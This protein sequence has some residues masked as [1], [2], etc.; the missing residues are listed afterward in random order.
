MSSN[1]QLIVEEIASRT[2]TAT[3]RFDEP[4]NLHEPFFM[5][6]EKKYLNE[7]IDEGF[8]SYVGR[9]VGE[10]ERKLSEVFEVPFAVAMSNG[11]VAL[12]M[13][14]VVA[15]VQAGQEVIMP[16]MSFIA[17]ANAVSHL[18][19]IPHFVDSE[20]VQMGIDPDKLREYLGEI[21]Q[22]GKNKHTGRRIAAIMPVHIWGCAARMDEIIAVAND[23]NIPIIEDAAEA[24]GAK[25]KNRACGGAGLV[26]ATSF[27]GNK[28]ITTGG[29]GAVLTHDQKIY[30][31]LRHLATTAKIPHEY[32]FIHD[33][34]GYNHRMPNINAALGVAQLENLSQ[35]L[36]KKSQLF[37]NYC[38][39]FANFAY[40]RIFIPPHECQS[41]HWLIGLICN[42]NINIDEILPSLHQLNIKARPLWGL[43]HLQAPYLNHPKSPDLSCAID[44]SKRVINL[45]SSVFLG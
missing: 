45:P 17:S 39:Y 18:G 25:Y 22:N 34:I 33:E 44:L 13:A 19:A 28:I 21:M 10:F 16:T 27:N 4:L 1:T 35:Y 23:F 11:T 3:K 36:Q 14:C 15:G 2:R 30:N 6:N 7:C 8:V 32:H 41:N 37:E 5:G 9:F 20:S 38:K 24:V 26:S 42:Q 31:H 40:G 12:T 43:I 29:G